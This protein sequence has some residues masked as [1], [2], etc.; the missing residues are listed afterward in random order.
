MNIFT[1]ND[2]PEW[3]VQKQTETIQVSD[4]GEEKKMI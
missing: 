3:G 2:F 1:P 4:G